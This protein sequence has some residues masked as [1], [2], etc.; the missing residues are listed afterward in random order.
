MIVPITIQNLRLRRVFYDAVG[1][2]VNCFMRAAV[3]TKVGSLVAIWEIVENTAAGMQADL[4]MLWFRE[5][6]STISHPG[7][8][9]YNN[10]LFKAEFFFFFFFFKSYVHCFYGT[11]NDMH[12]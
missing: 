11:R 10:S 12:L 2:E 3:V 9:F 4:H 8:I 6:C 5:H 1:E 7:V